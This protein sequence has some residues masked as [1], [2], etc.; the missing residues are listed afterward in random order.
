MNKDLMQHLYRQ[1][2]ERLNKNIIGLT[3]YMYQKI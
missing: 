1:P 3:F 2:E